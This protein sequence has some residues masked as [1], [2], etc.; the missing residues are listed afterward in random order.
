MQLIRRRVEEYGFDYAGGFTAF[1][2]HA[3]A[4]A[5]I[6]FDKSDPAQRA[7]VGEL[8]PRLIADAAGASYASYRAHVDFMD[9]I[10]DQYDWGDHAARHL[11]QTIKDAVDPNGILSPGKQGI[12]PS[13][14][15]T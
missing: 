12:W 6:S 8:F 1:P 7:S 9:L 4:L 3:I 10:A 11:Q 2:R 13:S 15:R 14:V 5:L